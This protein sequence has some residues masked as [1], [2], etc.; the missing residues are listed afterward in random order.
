MGVAGILTMYF[1]FFPDCFNQEG[2]SRVYIY[3]TVKGKPTKA[4]TERNPSFLVRSPGKDSW[5]PESIRKVP[6][7]TKLE[8]IPLRCI[9]IEETQRSTAKVGGTEQ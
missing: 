3:A 6:K 8:K 1:S 2:L 5:E 9:C 7:S 4:L